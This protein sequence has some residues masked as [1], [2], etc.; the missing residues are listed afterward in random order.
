MDSR[1]TQ[2]QIT[3]RWD[4]LQPNRRRGEITHLP[5]TNGINK[6]NTQT[7]FSCSF[8]S[9]HPSSVFLSV[10]GSMSEEEI[11][12]RCRGLPSELL[13]NSISPML[14]AYKIHKYTTASPQCTIAIEDINGI[15]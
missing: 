4:I 12:F 9:V 2:L 13:A 1:L 6:Q 10:R 15:I 8:V 14:V 3:F 7:S 5:T 11:G